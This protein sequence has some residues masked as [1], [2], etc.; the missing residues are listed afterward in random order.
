MKN[1]GTKYCVKC[2]KPSIMFTGHLKTKQ[3]MAL[4]NLI[5]VKITCGWCSEECHVSMKSESDGCFGIYD[6]SIET[7]RYF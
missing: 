1:I 5:D 2:G 4:G 6:N 7:I 3:K